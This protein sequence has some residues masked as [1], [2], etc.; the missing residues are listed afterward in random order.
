MNAL[1]RLLLER[2]RCPHGATAPNY[3]AVCI[4]ECAAQLLEEAVTHDAS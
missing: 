2:I 3:C 4:A 1:Y